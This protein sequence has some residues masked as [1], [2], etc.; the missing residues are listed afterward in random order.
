LS[1]GITTIATDNTK[2]FQRFE[3]TLI[4]PFKE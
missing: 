3:I 4:N 1:N 2:D